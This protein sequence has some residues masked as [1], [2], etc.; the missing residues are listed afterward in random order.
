MERTAGC[1]RIA[2]DR[3]LPREEQRLAI[4]HEIG[5]ALLH[6]G[7]LGRPL[8][9]LRKCQLEVQAERFAEELLAPL[10]AVERGTPRVRWRIVS[11]SKHFEIP[12][13]LAARRLDAYRRVTRAR[14][15]S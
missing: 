7:H 6:A 2:F 15:N 13:V 9:C 14:F 11:L 1:V 8:R 3:A 10:W 5:H 4:A 12:E